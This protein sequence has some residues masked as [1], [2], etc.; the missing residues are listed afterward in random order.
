MADYAIIDEPKPGKLARFVVR[1]YWAVVA[2][3]VA[4]A[5][6]AFPWLI[7]NAHALGSPSKSRE[8]GGAMA[9]F[10]AATGLATA[11]VVVGGLG[12][13]AIIGSFLMLSVTV[14]KAGVAF[15]ATTLQ[16]RSFAQLESLGGRP[17]NPC[18]V[19]VVG[20]IL[21]D[22]LL[23]MPLPPAAGPLHQIL[24]AVFG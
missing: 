6:L 2:L 24:W 12:L 16:S 21:S 19:L 13:P 14:M 8:I 4:G 15:W 11:V 5:W 22:L 7:F 23:P 3:L 1:P 18:F 10:A 17:M 9:Y 20:W